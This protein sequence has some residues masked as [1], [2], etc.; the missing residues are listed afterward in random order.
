MSGKKKSRVVDPALNLP[1]KG[2]GYCWLRELEWAWI[3]FL[4]GHLI[5]AELG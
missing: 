5:K 1:N 4:R 3:R 2:Y